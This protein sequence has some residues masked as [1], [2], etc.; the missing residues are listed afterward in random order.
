MVTAVIPA[1][2]ELIIVRVVVCWF[3]VLGLMLIAMPYGI[4]NEN[5]LQAICE[6]FQ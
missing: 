1:S 5:R 2:P 3:V 6:E 4:D